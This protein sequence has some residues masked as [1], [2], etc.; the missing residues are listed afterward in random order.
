V[1][2]RQKIARRGAHAQEKTRDQTQTVV[3]E[4]GGG[5]NGLASI[6]GARTVWGVVGSRTQRLTVAGEYPMTIRKEA[7]KQEPSEE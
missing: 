3:N 4:D 5:S 6:G 2:N 1:R 7:L